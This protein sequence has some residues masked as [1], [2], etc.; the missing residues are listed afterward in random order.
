[1]SP[2][3]VHNGRPAVVIIAGVRVFGLPR[4]GGHSGFEG[5]PG[6][7]AVE[8]GGSA[9]LDKDVSAEVDDSSTAAV[10]VTAGLAAG[11]TLQH[12]GGSRE[13]LQEQGP[14]VRFLLAPDTDL[15]GVGADGL[16][17]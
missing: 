4:Y 12:D 15:H 1:M 7:D 11:Q 9:A 5:Q 16:V 13:C 2:A 17:L 10:V 14:Q 3:A 6:D 8:H